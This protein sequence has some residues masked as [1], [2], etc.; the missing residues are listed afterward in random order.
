MFT[1]ECSNL[2][3]LFS[4]PFSCWAQKGHS[5]TACEVTKHHTTRAL[6]HFHSSLSTDM[7]AAHWCEAAGAKQGFII[8][9]CHSIQKQENIEFTSASAKSTIL[10]EPYNSMFCYLHSSKSTVLMQAIIDK[11]YQCVKA[12]R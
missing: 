5:S 2:Q 9:T 10:Q 8:L 11:Y 12:T 7:L 1:H 3:M 4:Q 6:L